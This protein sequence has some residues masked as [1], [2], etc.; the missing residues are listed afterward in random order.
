MQKSNKMHLRLELFLFCDKI[1]KGSD[2]MKPY[3]PKDL[4][5][6]PEIDYNLITKQLLLSNTA[7]SKYDGMLEEKM[8]NEELFLNPITKKEAVL[9]SKIEGTQATVTELLELEAEVGKA[10]TLSKYDD[11]VEITNYNQAILYA[12]EEIKEKG[13][14]NLYMIRNIHKILLKGARGENMTPGEFRKEQNWIG[15]PGSTIENASFIPAPPE[16]LNS[17]LEQ[18]EKYI[19]DYEELSRLV[20]AAIIH[21]QFEKIHP[22][23]DGNGRI[24]RMLIPLFL[25]DKKVIKKPVIYISEYFE[26]HK[27]EY[28]DKLNNV[29]NENDQGWIDWVIF[30]LKAIEVQA[31]KNIEKIR[32]LQNLYEDYKL[33]INEILNSKNSI[34]IVDAIFRH[35]IFKTNTVILDITSKVNINKTTIQRYLNILEKNEILILEKNKKRNRKY[36]FQALIKAIQ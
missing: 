23:R 5:F 6:R 15:S 33:R 34:Y 8:I 27:E 26:E 30:F 32:E 10:E 9:S 18:L 24:G 28:Y 4:P 17:S 25:Y 12:E 20:Q 7:V 14:M 11:F 19:L 2:I 3:I 35:P 36:Y 29:N 16:I 13:K 21:V 31:N 22:F 1:K